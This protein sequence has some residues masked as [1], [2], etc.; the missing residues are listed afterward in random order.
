MAGVSQR[1][2]SHSPSEFTEALKGLSGSFLGLPATNRTAEIPGFCVMTFA[3][4]RLASE[5]FHF[6]LAMLCEGIGVPID[7][8][9]ATLAALRPAAAA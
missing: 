2:D 9:R 4:D 7:A 8:V 1:I 5:R 3:E 6:D